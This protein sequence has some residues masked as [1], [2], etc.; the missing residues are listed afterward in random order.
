MCL[1]P[2]VVSKYLQ[3]KYR[4]SCRKRFPSSWV[5][6]RPYS[7]WLHI[8]PATTFLWPLIKA[9]VNL[10]WSVHPLRHKQQHSEPNLLFCDSVVEESWSRSTAAENSN[11]SI[12]KT[13]TSTRKN[14]FTLVTL[15]S[16]SISGLISAEKMS[17]ENWK[18]TDVCVTGGIYYTPSHTKSS[19]LVL[20]PGGFSSC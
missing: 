4:G 3:N 8:S 5:Q 9:H 14:T 18:I 6:F 20:Q 15:P 10:W 11:R 12:L 13:Y 16:F 1:S 19:W 17:I 7:Y 2:H